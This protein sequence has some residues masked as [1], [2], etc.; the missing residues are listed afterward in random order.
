ME[1]ETKDI[2]R[3][4]ILIGAAPIW[5][6]F[7]YTLWKD[8]NSALRH[9][10]GLFGRAPSEVEKQRLDARAAREPD[11]LVS[12]PWVRS[13]ERRRPR[14]GAGRAS[15][16]AAPAPRFRAGGGTSRPSRPGFR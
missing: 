16:H 14:M 12:E 13:G 4:L 6:P 9:E 1:N 7:L 15:A 5:V 2:L 3:W 11:P 8:F 10:G